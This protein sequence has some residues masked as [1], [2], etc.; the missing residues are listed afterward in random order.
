MIISE[1][2]QRIEIEL[3]PKNNQRLIKLIWKMNHDTHY[4]M[5]PTHGIPRSRSK[6]D[7]KASLLDLE[8]KGVFPCYTVHER[9]TVWELP[10]DRWN[11]LPRRFDSRGWVVRIY[12]QREMLLVTGEDCVEPGRPLAMIKDQQLEKM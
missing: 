2:Y 3:D 11:P 10:P 8:S 1:D 6:K 9:H 7:L 12:P 5:S 4:M